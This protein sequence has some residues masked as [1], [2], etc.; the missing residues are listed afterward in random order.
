C[1]AAKSPC[2]DRANT[3]A[4]TV[5]NIVRVSR[6]GSRHGVTGLTRDR[7]ALPRGESIALFPTQPVSEIVSSESDRTGT[8]SRSCDRRPPTDRDGR[9]K[10]LLRLSAADRRSPGTGR[11]RCLRGKNPLRRQTRK[12][13]PER[14][15]PSGEYRGGVGGACDGAHSRWDEPAAA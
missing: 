2:A 13:A 4:K 10:G 7:R 15:K 3:S 5:R 11:R 9:A 1:C 12:Q 8:R 14:D 6:T